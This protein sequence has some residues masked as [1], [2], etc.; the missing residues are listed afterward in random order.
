MHGKE[1]EELSRRSQR[2]SFSVACSAL[3]F[4]LF[5]AVFVRFGLSSYSLTRRRHTTISGCT[6][7]CID[8]EDEINIVGYREIDIG[9]W[10]YDCNGLVV[11]KASLALDS[12]MM[13]E[14]GGMWASESMGKGDHG[15]KS[16]ENEGY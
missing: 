12:V 3:P 5:L 13:R 14:V 9:R 4:C 11:A 7:Y 10:R 8:G 6:F 1:I 15:K 2:E 16:K